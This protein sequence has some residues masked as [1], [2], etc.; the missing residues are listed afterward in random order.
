MT[1]PNQNSINPERM[2]FCEDMAQ[3][4]ARG[5]TI[6]GSD[7]NKFVQYYGYAAS[8]GKEIMLNHEAASVLASSTPSVNLQFD[9]YKGRTIFSDG[10]LAPADTDIEKMHMTID[11]E[12]KAAYLK[13]V[14]S[15]KEKAANRAGRLINRQNPYPST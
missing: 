4:L 5:Y 14:K 12:K 6:Q 8:M 2:S 1:T 7:V 10:N 11:E 15:K 3:L 9:K 13:S